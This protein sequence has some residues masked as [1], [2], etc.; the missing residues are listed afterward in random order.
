MTSANRDRRLPSWKALRSDAVAGIPGAIAGVP[1][2]MAASVLAGVNPIHGLYASFAGPI[3]GG[4]AASTE[5][6]VITTTSAAALAAGEAIATLPAGDRP[7]AL[8]LLTLLAGVAMILA[9]IVRLGRYT[10]FVSHSV[11]VGFLSGVA[12][13]IVLGQIPD[14][15]GTR[16]QATGTLAIQK[17]ASVLLHPSWIDVPTLLTGLAAIAIVVFLRPT[18]FSKVGA[19]V[20]LIV[21]TA[22]AAAADAGV[23]TVAGNGAI[24]TGIPL[25]AIPSLDLFSIHLL[26]GALSVAAIVIVQGA[27]VSESA[28]N[29]DGTRTEQNRDFIAQGL[30]NVASGLFQ[31]QPVGGSVGRTALN[32]ST[33]ART[34]W[35]AIAS[36]AWMIAIL[37][38]FSGL[39]GKV[40]LATLAG[41]LIAA[42]IGALKT[43]EMWTILRTGPISQVVL[44]TTFIATLVLPIPAAVGIGVALSLLLQLNQEAMDLRVVE[45]VLTPDGR[46][47][48]RPA[49]TALE[50]RHVTMLDA[51][52]S[53][54][55]AGAKTLD[56]RLPDPGDADTP[57]V[58]LR[59]RGR[60]TLGSTFFTVADV[61]A[62]RLHA[63]GGRLYLSGVSAE[64]AKQMRA[65]HVV[66]RTEGLHI[67]EATA[68]IGESSLE[69]YDEATTWL[70]AR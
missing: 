62:A 26:V 67:V 60:T 44:L 52:G 33:G 46:F 25:P 12:V 23:A 35:A 15:T 4:A 34:R 10:R 37:V 56:R 38:A 9:G 5:L 3:A 50:S 14:L 63:L 11:M 53:L 51:Y 30:G 66:E 61:Y 43:G 40:A 70:A 31:G 18:R 7:G 24:P 17:A 41:L 6:M 54:L 68:V 42:A 39:I 28:P 32:V 1:D 13:N 2:G 64:L 65:A 59:L 48:E 19:L 58:V 49:P 55:Y 22:I 57:V 8:F 21:P 45:L 20:A 16:S 27:G 69:A 29:L 47:E 36:G